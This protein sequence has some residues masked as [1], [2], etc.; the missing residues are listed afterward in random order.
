MRHRGA[1]ISVVSLGIHIGFG[2]QQLRHHSVFAIV[3]GRVER[4]TSV[5]VASFGLEFGLKIKKVQQNPTNQAVQDQKSPGKEVKRG[6]DTPG[7]LAKPGP[8]RTKHT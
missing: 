5:A 1:G 3:C 8:R 7:R 2:P 4:G 6:V